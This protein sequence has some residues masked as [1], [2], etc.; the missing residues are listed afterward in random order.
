MFILTFTDFRCFNVDRYI[1]KYLFSL[2]FVTTCSLSGR[3]IVNGV[4]FWGGGVSEPHKSPPLK[5]LPVSF[6]L[7]EDHAVADRM[8]EGKA[9]HHIH[10][11]PP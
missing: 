4:F 9:G 5:L 1:S 3:N 8:V 11:K 2:N 10:V 6:E 7:N